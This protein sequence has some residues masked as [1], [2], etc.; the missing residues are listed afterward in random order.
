[1]NSAVVDAVV[2]DIHRIADA[3][4]RWAD[5]FAASSASSV[6]ANEA[7]ERTLE[8]RRQREVLE[9]ESA[10]RVIERMETK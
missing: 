6:N 10:R 5:A 8:V 7:C 4:A 9:L 1:M 3:I 2:A